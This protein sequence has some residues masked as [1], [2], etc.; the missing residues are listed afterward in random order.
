MKEK[1]LTNPCFKLQFVLK[2]IR[3]K[4]KSNQVSDKLSNLI[5]NTPMNQVLTELFKER[6]WMNFIV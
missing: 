1:N 5:Q 4:T 6:K 3:V 2:D